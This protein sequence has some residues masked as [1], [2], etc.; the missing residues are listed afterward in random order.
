MLGNPVTAKKNRSLISP[1]GLCWHERVWGHSSVPGY[2][3]RVE[4]LLP[5]SFLSWQAGPF[6]VLWLE[7]A[8]FLRAFFFNYGCFSVARFFSTCLGFIRQKE[9]S[10]N[11]PLY[12]FLGPTVPCLSTFFSLP[13]SVFLCLFCI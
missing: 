6:L 8:G 10:G 11:S 4:Q 3:S 2:L 7:K 13:V 12:Y 9:N 1:V 5:K